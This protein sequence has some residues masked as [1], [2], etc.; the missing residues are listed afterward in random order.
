MSVTWG[1]LKKDVLSL[2]FENSLAYDTYKQN[3]ITA[4]NAALNILCSTVKPLKGEAEVYQQPLGNLILQETCTP[5][6]HETSPI[7]FAA[8]SATAYYFEC[9]GNGE[10]TITSDEDTVTLQMQSGGEFVAYRGFCTGD[11]TLSFGGEYRYNIRNVALYNNTVSNDPNEIPVYSQYR[12]YDMSLLI[13]EEFIGFE[14]TP[15]TYVDSDN[16]P[17]GCKVV[18]SVLHVPNSVEGELC[19]HYRRRQPPITEATA[20]EQLIELP[21]EQDVLFPLL[22]AH[23]V[24]LEDNERK[25]TI[26]WNKFETL[27]Q[28]IPRNKTGN[29]S[30]FKNAHNW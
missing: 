7:L 26:Y 1:E 30:T 21:P 16:A 17:T 29:E 23:Q 4:A 3:F 24:W 27:R 20:D 14:Q 9:D 12:E 15:V 28:Q 18:G 5:V 6:T 19:I 22:M 13:G 25:A 11:V 10:V 2:G 8:P